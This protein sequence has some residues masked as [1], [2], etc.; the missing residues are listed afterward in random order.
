MV[1]ISNCQK[2]TP[3]FFTSSLNFEFHEYNKN[4]GNKKADFNYSRLNSTAL[5][6]Q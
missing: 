5:T 6:D 2:K 4:D 3:A 1:W